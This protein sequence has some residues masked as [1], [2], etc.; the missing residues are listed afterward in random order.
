MRSIGAVL[1]Q[2][3]SE[4]VMRCLVWVGDAGKKWVSAVGQLNVGIHGR[5]GKGHE[6]NCS[7]SK[8]SRGRRVLLL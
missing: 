4:E 7:S 2:R 8:L 6:S 3:S 5:V 1:W